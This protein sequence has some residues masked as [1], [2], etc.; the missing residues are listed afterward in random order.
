MN[1]FVEFCLEQYCKDSEY[2][3]DQLFLEISEEMNMLVA[4]NKVI[5]AECKRLK[6]AIKA[7][8]DMRD[9][10]ARLHNSDAHQ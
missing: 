8:N 3:Q 6:G 9:T 1:E 5:K 2:S 10:I 4:T 7:A